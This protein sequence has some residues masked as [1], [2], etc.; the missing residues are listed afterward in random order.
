MLYSFELMLAG[1][2]LFSAMIA[3]GLYMYKKK[4]KQSPDW[5]L[6]DNQPSDNDVSNG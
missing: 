1:I 2:I 6:Q 5:N 3:G 4:L